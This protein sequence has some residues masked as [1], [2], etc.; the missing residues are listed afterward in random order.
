[1]AVTRGDPS[2]PG[3]GAGPLEALYDKLSPGPGRLASE[4]AAH[5]RARIHN[6]MVELVGERGYAAVRM[7][8]VVRLAGVSTRSFY[9]NFDS[10]ED[11]F[12]RT[13][14]LIVRGATR[15][16]GAA[17]ADEFDWR[18]RSR[19]VLNAFAHELE[20][21]PYAA[22]LALVDAFEAGMEALEQAWRAESA[23]EAMFGEAIAR[24]PDGVIVPPLI[25]EGIVAGIVRVARQR[26]LT[27]QNRED[28]KGFR[29]ELSEWVLCLM[30]KAAGELAILDRRSV[31]AA[32]EAVEA[33]PPDGP[34]ASIVAAVAGLAA[35]HG[36]PYL[37]IPRIRVAAGVSRATFDAHFA[38]VDDCFLA[39]LEFQA[40]QA[41]A[42]AAH[43][44]K[45]GRTW[46]GGV[47]RA[48]ASLCA[49][50]G[51]NPLLLDL[52]LDDDFAPGTNGSIWR[53]RLTASIA[54]QI[55]EGVP[56]EH[57]NHGLAAEASKNAIWELFHHSMVRSPTSDGPRIAATLA[58]MALV[59]TI[60]AA[61][62]V[63]A[64]RG[65]QAVQ[66]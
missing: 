47:Y 63:A 65:E 14:E 27:G 42:E 41:L 20:G 62:S 59:P 8:D 29:D 50:F 31:S 32:A 25:M 19:L 11:C 36:Y 46:A 55:E 17:Q 5:Q 18:E 66:G 2:A 16:I 38:D 22:R 35:V 7:R 9:E 37:T 64:I 45:A 39:A 40:G 43:A 3:E 58:Y 30:D 23:F 51:S 12:L 15:R 54:A 6:A 57:R 10:K 4:V 33:P 44:Q 56:A 34:R 21:G 49:S 28:L 1:M 53:Q 26:L 52:C 24:G 13:H 61:A 60:D 48:I